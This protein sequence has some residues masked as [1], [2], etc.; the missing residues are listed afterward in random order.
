MKS[1]LSKHP[2]LYDCMIVLSCCLFMAG[3]IGITANTLGVFMSAIAIDM[4]TGI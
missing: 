3:A 4:H 1:Y 2:K